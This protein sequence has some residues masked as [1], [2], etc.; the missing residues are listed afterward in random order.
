MALR[1]KGRWGWNWNRPPGL[2]RSVSWAGKQQRFLMGEELDQG[3]L[4]S[5]LLG[6]V[7]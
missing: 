3:W 7:A 6:T 4:E 2:L 1:D 5:K